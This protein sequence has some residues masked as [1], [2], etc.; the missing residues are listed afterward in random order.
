MVRPRAPDGDERA[1]SETEN[2][3][4]A[5]RI[6][7]EGDWRG[8]LL[9]YLPGLSLLQVGGSFVELTSSLAIGIAV[10]Y[11][12]T[13]IPLQTTQHVWHRRAAAGTP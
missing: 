3:P 10:A 9:W 7:Q 4:R 11:V 1:G 2:D 12:I 6:L 13:R 8:F 5:G